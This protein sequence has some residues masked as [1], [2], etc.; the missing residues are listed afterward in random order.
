MPDEQG[1]RL[2]SDLFEP[3]TILP[4]QWFRPA[5]VPWTPER[6]LLFAAFVDGVKKASR[7]AP[8]ARKWM[9]SNCVSHVFAYLRLCE[10]FSLEPE[11]I[12]RVVLDRQVKVR[13]QH[14]L[15]ESARPGVALRERAA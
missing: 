4:A 3:E 14:R 6:R 8:S 1:D 13:V 2:E 10:A 7:G 5:G 12:R 11:R 9:R 15:A